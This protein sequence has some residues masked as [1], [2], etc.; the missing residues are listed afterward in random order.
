[1]DSTEKHHILRLI[2]DHLQNMNPIYEGWQFGKP[3][4]LNYYMEISIDDKTYRFR[5]TNIDPDDNRLPKVDKDIESIIIET[6]SLPEDVKE[7]LRDD[8]DVGC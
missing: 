2:Y 3:K 6:M 4:G 8:G 5:G 7:I 1:M